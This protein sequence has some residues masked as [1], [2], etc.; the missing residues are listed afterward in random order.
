[1]HAKLIL[2]EG[3]KSVVVEPQLPS[4]IGRGSA[5]DLRLPD[6]QASRRHCE[7][8]EYEGQLAVRD[9]GSANGTMVNQHRIEQDTL[10]STGDTL[11]IGKVT[12][13]ID[14]GDGPPVGL[15]GTEADVV[16]IHPES[17]DST[18]QSQSAVLQYHST[19]E[20]SVIGLVEDEASSDDDDDGL[21]D[22]LKNLK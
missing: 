7:L 9:L 21:G 14:V 19:G 3:G 4:V 8:Y 5:A 1:M 20:G 2:I 11:T 16:N 6:S 22:F 17:G 10:L 13:R 18:V 15:P 12:F